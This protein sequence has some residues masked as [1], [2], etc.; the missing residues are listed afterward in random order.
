VC[1]FLRLRVFLV[2][3]SLC[4]R[5][6]CLTVVVVLPVSSSY[7]LSVG[8]QRALLF[9]CAA[10]NMAP[11]PCFG[12]P[13]ALP[14]ATRVRVYR[15]TSPP[16][17]INRWSV[18]HFFV[19]KFSLLFLRVSLIIVFQCPSSPHLLLWLCFLGSSI[20]SSGLGSPLL[21]CVFPR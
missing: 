19:D 10:S 13:T 9:P 14:F 2:G 1:L 11:G 18:A 6:G 4:T 15:V 12:S 16:S 17:L 21:L 20:P 7:C 8:H 3:A 5:G